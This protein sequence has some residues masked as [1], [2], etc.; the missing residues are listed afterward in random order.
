MLKYTPEHMHC[1]AVCW[2]PLV[3][4]NTGLLAYNPQAQGFRISATGE[5]LATLTVGTV[6][7]LNQS[8]QVVK[9]LKLI[10]YPQKIYKNTA[11]VKDMFSSDLE[12][13][14][15]QGARIRTVSGIRGQVK[16]AVSTPLGGFRA[17]FEDKVLHSDIIFLRA[18]V[19]VQ[20]PQY[21][22][23]VFNLLA[24]QKAPPT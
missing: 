10:G 14:K 22:N 4:P 21:Y 18:W 16:K 13:A 19:P 1:H 6:L 2:G 17:T 20:I 7:D 15:F 11:I 23:P 8:T 12:V 5:Q 24:D 3:P 9:K